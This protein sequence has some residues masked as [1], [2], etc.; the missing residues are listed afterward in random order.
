MI[1]AVCGG[2]NEGGTNE[3][4]KRGSQDNGGGIRKK[5]AG[6]EDTWKDG[7]EEV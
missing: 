3:D 1:A 7:R 6:E 2:Q 5:E 4:G